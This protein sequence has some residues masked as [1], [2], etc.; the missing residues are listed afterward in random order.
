[1][2]DKGKKKCFFITP[3]KKGN[4]AV[5]KEQTGGTKKEEGGGGLSS[6]KNL[7]QARVGVLK[8]NL[9]GA[10]VIPKTHGGKNLTDQKY[11]EQA[12]QH[13]ESRGGWTFTLE[14]EP[15]GDNQSSREK[16]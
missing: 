11:G 16:L 4:R 2:K 6:L 8:V 3:E 5:L 10:G 13:I 1:M 12:D 9:A 7:S 15:G 14:R